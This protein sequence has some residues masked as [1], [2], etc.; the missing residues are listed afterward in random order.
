M[1]LYL[2]NDIAIKYDLNSI[3]FKV[4]GGK[5]VYG[6]CVEVRSY[7]FKNSETHTE[8]KVKRFK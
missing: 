8:F 5:K 4:I 3:M 2:P 6:R 1:T 7:G